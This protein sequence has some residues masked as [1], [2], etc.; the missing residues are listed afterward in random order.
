[1]P[2]YTKGTH[3]GGCAAIMGVYGPSEGAVQH[4][5]LLSED[6]PVT[7]GLSSNARVIHM[8]PPMSEESIPV[9][10]MGWLPGLEEETRRRMRLWAFQ[11]I[12][13]EPKIEYVAMPAWVEHHETDKKS[14]TPLY[15]RFSCAGFVLCC[16]RINAGIDLVCEQESLPPVDIDVLKAVFGALAQSGNPRILARI[17]ARVGLNDKG[18]CDEKGSWKVLLPAYLFHAVHAHDASGAGALPYQPKKSDWQFRL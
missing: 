15:T 5:A 7:L 18:S 6:I 4:L 17:L 10:L 14:G 2:V 9:H 1:M 11:Q 3:Q 12:R 8:G 13:Q 16:Y